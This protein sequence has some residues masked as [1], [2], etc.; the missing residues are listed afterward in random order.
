MNKILTILGW[1]LE[2]SACYSLG[3]HEYSAENFIGGCG[4]TR[5]VKLKYEDTTFKSLSDLYNKREESMKLQKG[6]K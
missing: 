3:G 1:A 5:C 6:D 2:I 4:C